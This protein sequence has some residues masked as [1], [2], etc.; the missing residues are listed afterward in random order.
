VS[1]RPVVGLVVG[2][3]VLAHSITTSFSATQV[4]A[5]GENAGTNLPPGLTNIIGIAAGWDQA[6][7]IRDNLSVVGWGENTSGQSVP[8][9]GLSNVI[10]LA[11]GVYHS[12]ALTAD[13]RVR[14]WGANNWGQTNVP[15][16]LNNVTAIA[17][18]AYFNLALRANG[19]VVAWGWES[20]ESTNVPPNLTN[21]IAI[22]A[23]AY[24]GVAVRSNGTVAVWGGYPGDIAEIKSIPPGLSN[25]VAVSAGEAYTVA[26]K[27][28]GRVIAWG[29]NGGYETSVPPNLTNVVA[30]ASRGWSHFALKADGTIVIWGDSA[31]FTATNLPAASAIAVGGTFFLALVNPD[32]ASTPPQ[33][34]SQ[35][36]SQTVGVGLPVTFSA[37]AVGY[38]LRYQWFHNETNLIANAT[39]RFLFLPAARFNQAGSYRVAVTNSAGRVVSDAATLGVLPALLLRSAPVIYV[40]GIVGSRYQIEYVNAVGNPDAW[41]SLAIITLTNSPH[42]YVDLSGIH[43]PT[44]FYR[45][46]AVP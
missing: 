11:G 33:I 24:H 38:G 13:G 2:F 4:I 17:A 3:V 18:G 26:L 29:N 32:Q 39:N 19:S 40:D 12:L 42:L 34:L 25:V 5:R 28:N 6:W 31:Y 46:T 7:A 15:N 43:Q 20:Y 45:A 21:V 22:A 23:G 44:R 14:A 8:P 27:A 30:I 10:A 37:Y 9:P 35:P 36:Q 41:A 1:Q 16:G